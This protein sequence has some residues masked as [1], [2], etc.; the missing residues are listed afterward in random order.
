MTSRL[1][2]KLNDLGVDTASTK[3]NEN[4]CLVRLFHTKFLSSVYSHQQRIPRLEHLFRHLRNLKTRGSLFRYG[5]RK[6]EMRKGG[7]DCMVHLLVVSQ[8]DTSI[9]W[10]PKKVRPH[11]RTNNLNDTNVSL[12]MGSFYVCFFSLGSCEAEGGATGG[13]H[14][15][16]G[17]GRVTR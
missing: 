7:D 17:S 5:N 1:K 8:L 9:L 11:C 3:A 10:G 6:L 4:F 13:L 2:R 16:G 12:R 15:R 14:G